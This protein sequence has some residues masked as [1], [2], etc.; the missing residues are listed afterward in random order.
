MP[1]ATA[2]TMTASPDT[3]QANDTT[4]QTGHGTGYP[5][6]CLLIGSYYPIVGGGE[7]HARL[8]SSAMNA[9]GANVFVLTQHRL[10]Q[11]P[12]FERFEGVDV[13]RIGLNNF[14][15]LGKYLMMPGACWKLLTLRKRY[16]S[17]YV[18]GHRTL[19]VVGVLMG[20]LLGKRVVLRSESC[21]ELSGDYA[22]SGKA[23]VA[24]ALVKAIIAMRNTVLKR[25]DRFLA[26]SRVIHEEFVGQ[27]VSESKIVQITNGV[28]MNRFQPAPP[29]QRDRLREQF[30][31]SDQRVLIYTGKLNRGKGLELL[32]RSWKT[33]APEYEDA[34]LV[35]VGGG[36][37]QHLSCEQRLLDFVAEHALGDRVTFTGN[38]SNVSEY[39]QAADLFVFPSESEALGLSLVEAMACGLPAVATAVG[40]ILDVIDDERVG[41]LSP[42]DDE[43]A[44]TAQV[45]RLLD[46][47]SLAAGLAK[48]G[49]ASVTRCFGMT[50]VARQHIELFNELSPALAKSG[51][52]V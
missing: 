35:L 31:W 46:D 3:M 45:R 7:S 26:I 24:R 13:Y 4:T 20:K 36:A 50:G 51:A 6:V 22:L 28:D 14:K 11:T 41:L 52:G 37:N 40:G 33:I 27:G 49:Q 9:A 16:D 1:D 10:A 32:L 23:G 30:G 15:R 19:G 5:R 34:H 21:T 43:L 2:I 44:F 12:R 42:V 48:A 39:L 25:T 38:V 18:C 17:I 29:E 47:P 8:L